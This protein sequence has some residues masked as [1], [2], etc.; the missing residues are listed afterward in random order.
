MYLSHICISLCR[1]A[2]DI[3]STTT[4]SLTYILKRS[5]AICW[6]GARRTLHAVPSSPSVPTCT[7]VLSLLSTLSIVSSPR[8]LPTSPYTFFTMP[9]N[10]AGLWQEADVGCSLKEQGRT[11]IPCLLSTS[12]FSWKGREGR[13]GRRKRYLHSTITQP[14]IARQ[15]TNEQHAFRHGTLTT[16]SRA[17]NAVSV[18]RRH[19]VTTPPLCLPTSLWTWP[20]FSLGTWFLHC[21]AF[22]TF[23]HT[24]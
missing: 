23:S 1:Y 13:I 7:P 18:A 2:R 5:M 21:Q 16:V 20:A 24:I 8:L 19:A 10:V 15:A 22:S 9:A 6:R 17:S 3:H 4:Y 12:P 14:R 11:D